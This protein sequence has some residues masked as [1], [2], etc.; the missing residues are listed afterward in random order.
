MYETKQRQQTFQKVVGFFIMW[1]QKESSKSSQIPSPTHLLIYHISDK[2][3]IYSF[4]RLILSTH[5]FFIFKWL[6]SFSAE[7]VIF[8]S[9]IYHLP[10]AGPLKQVFVNIS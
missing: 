9:E 6:C 8:H 10:R 3:K 1:V 2:M 4:K 5:P 7:I